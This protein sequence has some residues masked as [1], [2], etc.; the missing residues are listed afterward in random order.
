MR[1]AQFEKRLDFLGQLLVL[2]AG[3]QIER[4]PRMGHG[5]EDAAVMRGNE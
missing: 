2:P 5:K 3:L 4:S 1:H